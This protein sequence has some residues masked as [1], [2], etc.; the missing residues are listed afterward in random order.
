MLFN[1]AGGAAE[2]SDVPVVAAVRERPAPAAAVA[3][4][5]R[6]ARLRRCG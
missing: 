1:H 5:V 6:R 4:G 2:A 3:N